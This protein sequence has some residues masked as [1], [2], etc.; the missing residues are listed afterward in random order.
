M[1]CFGVWD[2][3]EAISG[4]GP[5]GRQT[6]YPWSA[7]LRIFLRGSTSCLCIKTLFLDEVSG[8]WLRYIICCEGH[9][10]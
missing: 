9:V 3:R 8:G 1:R 10:R 7:F 4:G 6:K 5:D 2:G